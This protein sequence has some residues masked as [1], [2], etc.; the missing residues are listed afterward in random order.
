MGC[1][2]GR[3]G[4]EE[5]SLTLLH[6]R[7]CMTK[8][9]QF[10][11]TGVSTQKIINIE[12]WSPW[13]IHS[14]RTYSPRPIRPGF[15]GRWRDHDSCPNILNITGELANAASWIAKL[16]FGPLCQPGRHT[17]SLPEFQQ[18]PYPL[19]SCTITTFYKQYLERA[20]WLK[21]WG[22]F[23]KFIVFLLV[24]MGYAKNTRN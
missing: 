3:S 23:N 10:F 20:P 16:Y 11:D 2:L 24:D 7:T 18:L 1:T 6:S 8:R 14:G 13:E 21:I 22:L 15:T 12:S 9:V 4:L 5:L 17:G 19:R